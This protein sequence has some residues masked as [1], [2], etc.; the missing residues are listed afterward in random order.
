MRSDDDLEHVAER[1]R[2]G[3]D[4]VT[5][6][7][8]P[9]ATDSHDPLGAFAFPE[10]ESD[11]SVDDSQSGHVSSPTSLTERLGTLR[12]QLANPRKLLLA[13][14]APVIT[15]ADDEETAEFLARA[16][17]T[18]RQRLLTQG[19]RIAVVI[20]LIAGPLALLLR[21]T[22]PSQPTVV[23]SA[24]PASVDTAAQFAATDLAQQFVPTW[25]TAH[26]GNEDSLGRFVDFSSTTNAQL[27]ENALFTASDSQIAAVSLIP[28][29]PGAKAYSVTISVDVAPVG[30]SSTARRYYQVPVAVT[31][32]GVRAMT[33][34]ASVPAPS[35]ALTVNLNYGNDLANNAAI[36]QAAQGFLRSMLTGSG[37]VTRF[38]SPGTH[39][40]AIT[41]AP[42]TDVS[43]V[44]AR[45]HE[46]LGT[47]AA[48]SPPDGQRARLLLSV[49]QQPVGA[50]DASQSLSG[51][52]ALTMT[53]RAGRWEVT[54]LDP[55]PSAGIGGSEVNS[56]LTGDQQQSSTS[57]SPSSEASTTSAAPTSATT[58]GA[59]GTG[60]SP[61]LPAATNDP[62][63]TV[64]GSA[65]PSTAPST[66]TA[67]PTSGGSGAGLLGSGGT[68]LGPR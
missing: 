53:G 64:Q 51:Q 45:S 3:A 67:A 13:R 32:S 36:V 28:G 52:Y 60:S 46:S 49:T 35:T 15:D 7:E 8:Q 37:D 63:E 20:A 55:I 5:T 22:S 31:P 30:G 44:S 14:K 29:T 42:Y 9:S 41:P 47:D 39:L 40:G 54:S 43:V 21:M 17:G 56:S 1:E 33:L 48:A 23:A 24:P 26:R 38:T 19:L 25:L 34:P 10:P 2:K 66:P 59:S 62:T 18:S 65:T 6:T 16:N 11:E 12:Q 57:E 68:D 61:L 58:Q 50:S 4:L 27:P